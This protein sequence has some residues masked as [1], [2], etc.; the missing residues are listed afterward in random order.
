VK[1]V[2]VYST[3]PNARP[4]IF[5]NTEEDARLEIAQKLNQAEEQLRGRQEVAD[6]M[7]GSVPTLALER[8]RSA[9]CVEVDLDL[10]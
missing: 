7:G 10:D 4:L 8:W 6:K 3:K 2:L 9:K 1:L 5:S